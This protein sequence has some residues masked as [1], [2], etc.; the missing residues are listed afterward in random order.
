LPG[1]IAPNNVNQL[2]LAASLGQVHALRYTPAGIPAIDIVL[3]HT[4][5][6]QQLEQTRQVKLELKATAF[7]AQAETLARQALGVVFEFHGF[8]VNSRNGK[9][10]VF[11]IQDFTQT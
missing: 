6:A 8:L 9:G 4:S 10:V 2:R 5:E 7:G 1:A 11:Q 3:E